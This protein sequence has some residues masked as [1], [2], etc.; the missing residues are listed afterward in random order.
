MSI[1]IPLSPKKTQQKLPVSPLSPKQNVLKKEMELNQAESAVLRNSNAQLEIEVNTLR[2]QLK[3]LK[4][5]IQFET[6]QRSQLHLEEEKKL[7]QRLSELQNEYDNQ[8]ESILKE[9]KQERDEELSNLKSKVNDFSDAKQNLYSSINES[10]QQM[11][12]VM[13]STHKQIKS[14]LESQKNE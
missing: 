7:E 2:K 9:R 14:F 6:N 11:K 8:V 3:Y 4:K 12:E 10:F 5:S 1:L 13:D